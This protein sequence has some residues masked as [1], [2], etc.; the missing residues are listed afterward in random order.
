MGSSIS[1]AFLSH[2]LGNRQPR[3]LPQG[4]KRT[5]GDA[6]GRFLPYSH[7]GLHPRFFCSEA[8]SLGAFAP[9]GLPYFGD[10]PTRHDPRSFSFVP[11]P[12]TLPSLGWK[13]LGFY[14]LRLDHPGLRNTGTAPEGL[15]YSRG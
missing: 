6:L 13:P 4:A 5:H 3:G 15:G 7:R 11:P 2:P 9:L 8:L 12:V 10:S 14:S 1:D